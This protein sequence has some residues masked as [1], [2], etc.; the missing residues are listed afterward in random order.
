MYMVKNGIFVYC[1]NQDFAPFSV[2][3]SPV[4]YKKNYLATKMFKINSVFI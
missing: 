4:K 3:L 2:I 1:T